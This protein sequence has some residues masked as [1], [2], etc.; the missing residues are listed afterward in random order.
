M[1][2]VH[3]M[4]IGGAGMASVA[5]IAKAYGYEISGCDLKTGGHDVKHLENIDILA[6]TPA[7]FYQSA[8]HP[9]LVEGQKRGILMTW[10][11]FMGKYL[12]KDKFVICIAGTH[13]KSTTTTMV[14]KLLLVDA[15]LDP[16]VEVGAIIPEWGGGDRVGK[17]KYFVS[18]ADEFYSN[19]LHYHPN[20][21]ILNNIELDHPEYFGTT[22]KMLGIFQKFID[23][24]K[25]SGTLIYNTDS[26]LI[27]KLKF[28]KNSIPYSISEF[29]N[30]LILK[31]PGDHNKANAMG[32]IKLAKLLK[33]PK[34]IYEK[35]L[36][37]FNGIDRRLQELGTVKGV[38]VIDD[39]ANH[40]TA[41]AANIKAVKSK[42]KNKPLWV[43]IEPHTFSRLRAVLPNLAP[44]LKDADH[45]IISKIFASREADP[46]DFTGA[47]IATSVPGALYIPEFTDIVN[48]VKSGIKSGANHV[49]LVMGSGNSDK[50]AREILKSL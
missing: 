7:V 44:A 3:F 9:E 22:G 39:Y 13:G 42:Y 48:H 11:E 28:P 45:V 17:S 40:P 27:H 47:D 37:N 23:Q 15:K 8:K 20:I 33:L 46:G 1:T 30:D 29:P 36:G 34:K 41:F 19:F 6:V 32:V 50:L 25:P 5:A 49:V 10:Q 16:T 18:E 43:I 35:S 21:V 4:G 2:R 12:H 14:G 26:P 24:I 31:V 38:T